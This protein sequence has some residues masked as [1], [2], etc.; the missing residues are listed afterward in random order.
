MRLIANDWRPALHA[1]L[2]GCIRGLNAVPIE[3]GGTDDHVHFLAGLKA[4]ECV[5]DLIREVKKASTKWIRAE[6]PRKKFAWQEGYGAFTVSKS[7]VDNL[8]RYIRSQ[9]EHHKKHSF[10]EEYVA[11][12]KRHALEYVERHLW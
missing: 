10:Q 1:Y 9:E 11:L 2:G 4:T 6:T 12:L 3:V 5:A 7:H 8:V